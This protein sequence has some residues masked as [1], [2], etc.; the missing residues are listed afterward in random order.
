MQIDWTALIE[1]IF[2]LLS[3]I[4]TAVLVPLLKQKLGDTKYNKLVE[5]IK[6]LVEAAEKLYSG[7]GRG[8]EK[9]L[10]VCNQATEYAKKLGIEIDASELRAIVESFV[11]G[12]STSDK[13][14]TAESEDGISG[15]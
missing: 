15:D 13:I 10:Y 9:L 12:L 14:S 2:A 7:S 3:V 6:V 1:G 11:Y 4:I 8:N 5:M